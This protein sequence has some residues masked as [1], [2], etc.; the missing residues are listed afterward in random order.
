M[1]GLCRSWSYVSTF[2]GLPERLEALSEVSDVSFLC[3]I[4]SALASLSGNP[5]RR[6]GSGNIDAATL[7][8]QSTALQEAGRSFIPYLHSHR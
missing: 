2:P 1:A 6:R 5:L 3:P 4:H 7:G 8:A